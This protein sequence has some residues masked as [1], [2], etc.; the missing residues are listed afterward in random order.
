MA[1]HLD[2]AMKLHLLLASQQISANCELT[3]PVA[4]N[5]HCLFNFLPAIFTMTDFL[6][7]KEA[8]TIWN[9]PPFYT[10][11]QGY[12]MCLQVYANGIGDGE[13]T[14]LSVFVALM[15]GEDDQHL[16][17][18]FESDISY[19]LVNWREDKQHHE[20]TVRFNRKNFHHVFRLP[21]ETLVLG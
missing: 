1:T 13:G 18:P 3:S 17:W 12:K 20:G 7:K 9:S 4:D 14:H 11:P 16:Q 15:R 8:G 19:Q 10:H 2:H 21:R 6:Q 5:M